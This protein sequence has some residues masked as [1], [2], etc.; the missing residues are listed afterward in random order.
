MLAY[1]AT[2][3]LENCG[4]REE[5][6]EERKPQLSSLRKSSVPVYLARRNFHASPSRP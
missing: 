4:K 6:L 1:R 5:L 3:N 2:Q